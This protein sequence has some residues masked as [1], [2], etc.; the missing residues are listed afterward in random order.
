MQ[1]TINFIDI[2]KVPTPAMDQAMD[3][4]EDVGL[5][6]A[7]RI[8]QALLF[9]FAVAVIDSIIVYVKDKHSESVEAT[10]QSVQCSSYTKP[11]EQNRPGVYY[12][13]NGTLQYQVNQKPYTLP[14][15]QNDIQEKLKVG[16]KDTVWYNPANPEDTGFGRG[17]IL[18]VAGIISGVLLICVIFSGLSYKWAQ[19]ESWM[20]G[21]QG[22]VE[23][24]ETSVATL[25]HGCLLV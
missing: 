8:F 19:E 21:L 11:P 9:L 16:D 12:A 20:R 1:K 14:A 24:T 17:N 2:N 10:F 15:S 7:R 22:A 6:K 3:V 25:E 5:T 13:C 4:V 18:K 23:E